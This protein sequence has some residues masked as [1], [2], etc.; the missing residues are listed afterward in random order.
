VV[1][2]A[3]DVLALVRNHLVEVEVANLAGV[4]G[5]LFGALLDFLLLFVLLAAL[6]ALLLHLL[7]VV[8]DF[9]AAGDGRLL[10]VLAGLHLGCVRKLTIKITNFSNA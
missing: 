5:G 2:S 9:V 3:A 6:D 10:L 7:D 4:F 8:K 1:E